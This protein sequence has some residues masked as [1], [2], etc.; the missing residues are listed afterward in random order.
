MTTEELTGS[1]K[2]KANVATSAKVAKDKQPTR[3][4]IDKSKKPIMFAFV[5]MLC[6]FEF[7]AFSVKK[8]GESQFASLD[9]LQ[10]NEAAEACVLNL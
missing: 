5:Q 2:R 9:Q 6:F 7:F 8:K 1:P 3:K 4:K 10:K